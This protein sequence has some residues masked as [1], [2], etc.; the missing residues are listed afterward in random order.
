M[1]LKITLTPILKESKKLPVLI[2]HVCKHGLLQAQLYSYGALLRF[3]YA[4]RQLLKHTLQVIVLANK[5]DL[6]NVILTVLESMNIQLI[7]TATFSSL[8]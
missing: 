7:V 6:Q 4:I 1:A 5:P 2:E 3:T 8:I